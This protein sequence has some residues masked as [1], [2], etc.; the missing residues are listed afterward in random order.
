VETFEGKRIQ[1]FV[2]KG[3]RTVPRE[4]GVVWPR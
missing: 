2:Y 3:V 1:K 4:Q